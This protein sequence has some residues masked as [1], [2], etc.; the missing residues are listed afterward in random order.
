MGEGGSEGRGGLEP[1]PEDFY[2]L[3]P[4]PEDFYALGPPPEDFHVFRSF[5]P[6][7][8][9]SKQTLERIPPQNSKLSNYPPF[10]NDANFGNYPDAA[11]V[12][13]SYNRSRKITS[14]KYIFFSTPPL[15]RSASIRV[16]V[17]V[18]NG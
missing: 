9:Q 4:P 16:H 6:C 13:I 7:G 10:G 5:K 8:R 3:E 15:S 18:P 17:E 1:L 12:I 14:S 2:G 11:D